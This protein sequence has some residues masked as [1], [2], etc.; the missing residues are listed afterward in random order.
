M[1]GEDG[2]KRVAIIGA[3]WSG[4]QILQSLR[5]RG[6]SAQIFEKLDL[7]GGTWTPALSYHSLNL[8][9]PRYMAS[10]FVHGKPFPFKQSDRDYLNGKAPAAEMHEY[11][12]DFARTQQLLPHIALSSAVVAIEYSSSTRTAMLRVQKTASAPATHGPFDLVVFASVSGK[13][14]LPPLDGAFGGALLH[15]SE[16]RKPLL[17][18]VVAKKKK[19]VV[20]GA[21]KS[22]CDMVSALRQHGHRNCVLLWAVWPRLGLFLAWLTGY[23]VMPVRSFRNLHWNASKFHFGSLNREQAADL[24]EV[25]AVQAEPARL[26]REGI[27]LKSGELLACDVIICATGYD[28]GFADVQLVKDGKK[29]VI[30]DKEPLLHHA[31]VPTFPC[32]MFSHSALFH[33]GPAR[34]VTQSAYI[35]Y[36]LNE[37][38]VDERAVRQAQKYMCKQSVNRHFVYGDH[39]VDSFVLHLVDLI[40]AGILPVSSFVAFAFNFFVF[41]IYEPMWLNV[42]KHKVVK[43]TQKSMLECL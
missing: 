11:L 14:S 6:M 25:E 21:G 36:V 35:S 31:L 20:L 24:R 7:I 33:V 26:C 41:S 8:H 1:A 27:V 43:E 22:G 30:D 2:V 34:G 5:E 39:F 19:V 32:L 9:S 37:L 13:P 38:T 16:L 12:N 10:V 23:M 4:L 40:W 3:G 17:D 18:E 28:T 15:S 42:G 29:F